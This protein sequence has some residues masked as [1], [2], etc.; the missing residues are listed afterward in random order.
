MWTEGE[1]GR[2]GRG[3]FGKIGREG[4]CGKIGREGGCGK[5]GREGRL[6][7]KKRH[8]GGSWSIMAEWEASARDKAICVKRMYVPCMALRLLPNS[9]SNQI[10]SET[11]IN[12]NNNNYCTMTINQ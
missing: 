12:K 2:I 7:K 5:I 1:F 6:K 9:L 11:I 3:G 8:R 4:G 10:T